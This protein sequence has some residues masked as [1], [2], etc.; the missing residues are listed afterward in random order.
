MVSRV[1]DGDAGSAWQSERYN[2]AEFG[3]LKTG[4]GV[5]VD[6]GPNV[7][8]KEIWLNLPTSADVSL[9]VAPEASMDGAVKV[10][11]AQ[12]IQGDNLK[13][14]V[15]ANAASAGQYVI[16]WFTRLSQDDSGNYRAYLA[17]V[18]ARG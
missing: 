3:G 17:E 10:R 1:F 18:R 6:L 15:P 14:S 13:F 16:V 4:V 2:S 8:P 12:N 11:D 9:Y 7:Q 5:V